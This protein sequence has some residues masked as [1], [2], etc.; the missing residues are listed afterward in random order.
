MTDN[1]FI[2]SKK[3]EMENVIYQLINEMRMEKE[4]L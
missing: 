3:Y 4:V 2:E 1:C